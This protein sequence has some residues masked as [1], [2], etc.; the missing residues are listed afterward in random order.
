MGASARSRWSPRRPSLTHR[1]PLRPEDRR[2]RR[3]PVHEPPRDEHDRAGEAGGEHHDAVGDGGRG[4]TTRAQAGRG[5]HPC[6]R[7]LAR[8][9]A[10]DARQHHG[11]HRE[12]RQRQQPGDRRGDPGRPRGDQE[13]DRVAEDGHRRRKHDRRQRVPV[14]QSVADVGRHRVPRPRPPGT[15]ASRR[16]RSTRTTPTAAATSATATSGMDE[17][18]GDGSTRRTQIVSSDLHDLA[19]GALPDDRP[20]A[21]GR[22]RARRARG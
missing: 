11:Q 20:Q 7:A 6:G 17:R 1:G 8:P 19:G 22:R 4:A 18:T 21:R 14:Q 13:H 10:A 3:S 9:P 5:E 12:Q 2:A 15:P 16:T